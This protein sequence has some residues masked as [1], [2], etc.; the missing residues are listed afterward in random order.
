MKSSRDEAAEDQSQGV[1]HDRTESTGNRSQLPVTPWFAS[2]RRWR[3]V[4][5]LKSTHTILRR[6]KFRFL[7]GPQP[8][9]SRGGWSLGWRGLACRIGRCLEERGLFEARRLGIVWVFHEE[10]IAVDSSLDNTFR[11]IGDSFTGSE[12]DACR[13]LGFSKGEPPW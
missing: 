3:S 1:C 2:R 8:R 4:R 10:I 11:I 13:Y 7:S 6:A 12:F 5:S 9:A